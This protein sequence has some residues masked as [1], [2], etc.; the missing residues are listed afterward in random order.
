MVI[1]NS[2]SLGQHKVASGCNQ[3]SSIVKV[4]HHIKAR[5]EIKKLTLASPISIL[6]DRSN[7]LTRTNS[8]I[9]VAVVLI[10]AAIGGNNNILILNFTTDSPRILMNH[11]RL[12][13]VDLHMTISINAILSSITCNTLQGTLASKDSLNH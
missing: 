4:V 12:L 11:L 9:G 7:L 13:R 1:L 8:I 2:I 3:P 5:L 10:L 6:I